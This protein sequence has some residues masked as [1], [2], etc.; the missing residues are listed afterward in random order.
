LALNDNFLKQF[1]TNSRDSPVG[2]VNMVRSGSPWDLVL[3]FGMGKGVFLL[4][5]VKTGFV[6]HT[7]DSVIKLPKLIAGHSPQSSAELR[8]VM[9]WT[10]AFVQL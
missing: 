7:V 10:L 4:R 1:L 8:K 2:I 6:S 5:N 3:I 9:T